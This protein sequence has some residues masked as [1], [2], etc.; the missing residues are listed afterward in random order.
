MS[1]EEI[2]SSYKYR[3][4]DCNYTWDSKERLINPMCPKCGWKKEKIDIT[5]YKL[6]SP[7][8]VTVMFDQRITTDPCISCSND[9]RNGGSGICNCILPLLYKNNITCSCKTL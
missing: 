6:D 3:C 9:P 4:N 5:T 1:V 2:T 7:S 8:N